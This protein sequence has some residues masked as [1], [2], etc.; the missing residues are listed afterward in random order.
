MKLAD[1][2]QKA[3]E[4]EIAAAP[5]GSVVEGKLKYGAA[6]AAGILLNL[7]D[8]DKKRV[9]TATTDGSG[10]FMYTNLKEGS[11]YYV[12]IDQDNGKIPDD[13]QLY[14]KDSQTG[15]MIAVA[16]LSMGSFGF[17]TLSMMEIE[18]LEQVE[19]EEED[20]V[21]VVPIEKEVAEFIVFLIDFRGI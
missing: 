8:A 13:A 17:S 1:D 2:A 6:G 3:A 11:Q 4:A 15:S 19:I 18:E 12:A 21:V 16:K 10:N 7:T 9:A 14:I 20:E 5:P